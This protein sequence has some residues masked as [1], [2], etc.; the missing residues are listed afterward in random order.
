VSARRPHRAATPRRPHREHRHRDQ[1]PWQ[2]R[3]GER[4]QWPGHGG[5]VALTFPSAA[6]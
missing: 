6:G 1:R 2:G 3:G 4:G 5:G